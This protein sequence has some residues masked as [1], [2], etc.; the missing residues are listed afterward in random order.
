MIR[1]TISPWYDNRKVRGLGD[2]GEALGNI[3]SSDFERDAYDPY[4]IYDRIRAFAPQGGIPL[5]NR[6]IGELRE[7]TGRSF[8]LLGPES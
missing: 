6:L 7:K 4:V 8:D 1:E 3:S 5:A 2:I